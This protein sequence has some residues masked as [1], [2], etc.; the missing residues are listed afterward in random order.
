MDCDLSVGTPPPRAENAIDVRSL[1]RL[2]AKILSDPE[3]D[4]GIVLY[5]GNF[6]AVSPLI[7]HLVPINM[8]M[9]AALLIRRRGAQY[10]MRWVPATDAR[11]G[12]YICNIC[13]IYMKYVIAG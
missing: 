9:F 10:V 11:Y 3:F 13:I 1:W 12:V 4:H 2:M 7:E 6:A 8:Q 5:H